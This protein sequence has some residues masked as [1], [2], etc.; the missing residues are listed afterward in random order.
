[1]H[2]QI[3]TS[4][5]S[6]TRNFVFDRMIIEH[7]HGSDQKKEREREKQFHHFITCTT[8]PPMKYWYDGCFDTRNKRK[9][10]RSKTSQCYSQIPCLHWKIALDQV[11]SLRAD[12]SSYIKWSLP[13]LVF[14]PS[15][16]EMKK[17]NPCLS[18]HSIF[19]KHTN[20]SI[21][22]LDIFFDFNFNGNTQLGILLMFYPIN[23]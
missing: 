6:T 21:P 4:N 18:R 8:L 9:E 10:I 22:K 14:I 17:F 12:I 23:G 3:K 15:N 7:E 20:Y 2:A 16:N 1:M 11:I 13:M 5:H 19:L